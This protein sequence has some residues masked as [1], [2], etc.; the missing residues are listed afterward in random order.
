VKYWT[1]F[2]WHD[3]LGFSGRHL[4]M[5]SEQPSCFIQTGNF[6]STQ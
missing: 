6:T 1:K 2:D 4:C 5:Y 3:I